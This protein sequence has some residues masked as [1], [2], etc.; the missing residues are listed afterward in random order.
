V[1]QVLRFRSPETRLRILGSPEPFST[2]AYDWTIVEHFSEDAYEREGLR[3]GPH[4][5]VLERAIAK[6]DDLHNV[7]LDGVTLAENL[8]VV[9]QYAA[10]LPW[11]HVGFEPSW[12]AID[13]PQGWESNQKR[14]RDSLQAL[15]S[16]LIIGDATIGVQHWRAGSELPLRKALTA[17]DAFTRTDDLTAAVIRLHYYAQLFLRH[18]GAHFLFA[19][20]LEIVRELLPGSSD[21]AKHASL[22]PEIRHGMTRSLAWLFEMSNSR[23]DTRHPITKKPGLALHPSMSSEEEVAFM[24][25][26]H[27][28]LT[29]VVCQRLGLEPIL[30][31]ELADI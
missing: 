8:D 15:E 22:P 5:V 10:G 6:I 24:K 27:T 20:A 14:V 19:K 26:S 7:Y 4:R 3:Y 31:G 25:N 2:T 21:Q 28:V 11:R 9:W 23:F 16:D 17:L 1:T 12:F 18:G 30:L 13:P 29:A